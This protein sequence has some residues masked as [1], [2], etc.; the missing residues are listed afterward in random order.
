MMTNFRIRLKA[1]MPIENAEVDSMTDLYA[2]ANWMERETYE[3]FG[4]K[5]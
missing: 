5:I 1:F 4:I 2:G 3:F